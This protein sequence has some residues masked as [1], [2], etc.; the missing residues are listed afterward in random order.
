VKPLKISREG[1]L[2][3][4]ALVKFSVFVVSLKIYWFILTFF[5]PFSLLHIARAEPFLGY[6][7]SLAWSKPFLVCDFVELYRNLVDDYVV[8]YARSLKPRDFVL[9]TEIFS[10]NRKGK[11][12]YLNDSKTRDFMKGLSEYFLT[13]VK[14]PRYRIGRKQELETLINE[15]A[16]LFAKYLRDERR[17]WN[18][19][20]VNL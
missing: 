20:I 11:R 17:D 19:R 13:E 7:H 16:M 3:K 4:R 15:E 1:S 6:L 8:D 12:E 9:K 10:S 18:P 14:I 2:L 5:F